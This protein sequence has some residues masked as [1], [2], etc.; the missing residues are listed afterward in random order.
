MD[1]KTI[2][3]SVLHGS[4]WTPEEIA[5]MKDSDLTIT[6]ILVGLGLIPLNSQSSPDK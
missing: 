5:A 1:A 2:A 3:E 4:Q 6:D